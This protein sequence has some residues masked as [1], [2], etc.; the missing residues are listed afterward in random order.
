[1]EILRSGL[2]FN[3]RSSKEQNIRL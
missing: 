3:T 2:L 1:L